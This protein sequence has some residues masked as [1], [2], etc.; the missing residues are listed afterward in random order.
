MPFMAELRSAVGLRDLREAAGGE[1]TAAQTKAALPIFKQYREKDGRFYFKLVK[2]DVLLLQSAGFANPKEAGS[3]IARFRQDGAAALADALRIASL[4][5][6]VEAAR[7]GAALDALKAAEDASNG[8][9]E[10]E[11]Y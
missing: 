9:G 5:E 1:A 6:G 11:P 7:A 8:Q 10:E 3:W 4:G 2:N